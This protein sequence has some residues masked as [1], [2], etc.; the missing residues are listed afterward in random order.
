MHRFI[1][2]ISLWI[3]SFVRLQFILYNEYK[4]TYVWT[5]YTSGTHFTVQLYSAVVHITL[6]NCSTVVITPYNCTVVHTTHNTLHWYSGTHY[7][8]Q[9]YS[10]TNY[11][12]HLYTLHN[13]KH[14][15]CEC[16]FVNDSI[17]HQT[18]A[19]DRKQYTYN[20]CTL[21]NIGDCELYA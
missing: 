1:G 7:T 21:Y 15:R 11:T 8:V 17:M 2:N 4:W 16:M 18:K 19:L 13:C 3:F 20:K 6:Y 12:A 10:G 9:L 14:K 5:L